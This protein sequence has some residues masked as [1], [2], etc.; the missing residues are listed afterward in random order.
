MG[1]DQFLFQKELELWLNTRLQASPHALKQAIFYAVLNG[2][3]RVR[4]ELVYTA[5]KYAGLSSFLTLR[6]AIAHELIHA[7]SLVHDDLPCM[8]NDEFRRGK[9]TNQRIF[10]EATALLV[11]DALIGLAS[12]CFLEM[13][14]SCSRSGFQKAFQFFLKSIGPQ[15]MIAGQFKDIHHSNEP[16]NIIH[17]LKTGALFSS[18]ILT[19]FMISDQDHTHLFLEA[20]KFAS[21]FGVLFQVADDL[22]DQDRDCNQ[23]PLLLIDHAKS[24]VLSLRQHPWTTSCLPAQRLMSFTEQQVVSAQSIHKVNHAK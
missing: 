11:G 22:E 6:I 3:K 17:E 16:S 7:Y 18:A 4:P 5:S 23:N 24:L 8:D 1:W 12:E 15:G 2:G 13:L 9:H 14:G 20:K 21:I 19:P 10:G